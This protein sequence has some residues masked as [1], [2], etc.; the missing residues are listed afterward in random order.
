MVEKDQS[1]GHDAQKQA[2]MAVRIAMIT[3]MKIDDH[4]KDQKKE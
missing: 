1:Q 4:E 2:E 3:N